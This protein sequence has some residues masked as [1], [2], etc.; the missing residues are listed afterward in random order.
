VH[1]KIYRDKWTD[2]V[3]QDLV[4]LC[5]RC[6]K[7]VHGIIPKHKVKF[8]QPKKKKRHK[9]VKKPDMKLILRREKAMALNYLFGSSPVVIK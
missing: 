2:T 4:T 8:Q 1:H 9:K 7:G 6:H 3:L 5:N